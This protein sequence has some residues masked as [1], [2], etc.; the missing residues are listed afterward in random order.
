MVVWLP[1]HYVYRTIISTRHNII[2]N[3][4]ALYVRSCMYC[5]CSCMH[6]ASFQDVFGYICHLMTGFTG[7]NCPRLLARLL[8]L[9]RH[10]HLCP[11]LFLS[12]YILSLIVLPSTSIA[13]NTPA[14][15]GKLDIVCRLFVRRS[16]PHSQKNVWKEPRT[17]V[18]P[19]LDAILHRGKDLFVDPT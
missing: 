3:C 16:D 14:T 9:P 7:R 18:M 12:R 6:K 13:T 1:Q 19:N 2:M 11:L 4:I 5:D 8:F 17:P 15:C 10:L